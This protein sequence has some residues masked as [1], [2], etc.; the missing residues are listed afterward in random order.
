MTSLIADM[1]NMKHMLRCKSC[2]QKWDSIF[3][4]WES[5]DKHRKEVEHN[6]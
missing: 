3:A 1:K 5:I 4:L 6:G 2:E